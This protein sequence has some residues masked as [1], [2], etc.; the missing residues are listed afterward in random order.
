VPA[1]HA[2]HT[3]V[4]VPLANVPLRQRRHP[5]PQ[6]VSLPMHVSAASV[7][8][9]AQ[10]VWTSARYCV[11]LKMAVAPVNTVFPQSPLFPKEQIWL[12]LVRVG[13]LHVLE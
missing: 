2:W 7:G 6:T 1:A 10:A 13:P 11:R 12:L 9:S 8:Y 4:P 3:L 5:V